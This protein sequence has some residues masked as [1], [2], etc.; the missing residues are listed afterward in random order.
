MKYL[1]VKEFESFLNSF[2]A[3]LVMT[4]FLTTMGLLV[5][6][7][8]DT[9]VLEYGFADMGTVFNV[10]PYVFIFLVP[11]I[12]MRSIAEERKS[13]TLELLFTK[14]ITDWD[15]VLGKFTASLLLTLLILAPTVV[16]YYSISQL[17]SPVGNIDSP[18]VV[19]SY[20]GLVFLGG[21]FCAIGLLASS[22]SSNQVIAFVVG[23]FLCFLLFAG[24]DSMA[25][26]PAL[27]SV[28]L[29]VRQIGILHHYESISKG[30][31]DSRDVVYF[32][33]VTVLLLLITRIN[34]SSRSW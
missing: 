23:A 16:Y 34:L 28:A 1:L 24:F 18:G 26:L 30:L 9:S 4:V 20:L 10:A 2:T 32:V 6:V 19:G 3:Y 8:P 25:S 29:T 11:A 21:V 27:S 17:G 33:S 14:P 12:T 31:I 15:I 7:F 22:L 13:G 5:W